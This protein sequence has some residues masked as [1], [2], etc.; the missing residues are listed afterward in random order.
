MTE[1]NI[2]TLKAY[3]GRQQGPLYLNPVKNRTTGK[4]LG[5]KNLSPAE[6]LTA[7][8]EVTADTQR[9]IVDGLILDLSDPVDEIDWAW[10]KENKEIATSEEEANN[11]PQAL[12]Y[13]YEPDREIDATLEKSDLEYEAMK[14]IKESTAAKRREFCMYLGM[15]V[16]GFRDKDV[17]EYLVTTVKAKNGPPRILAI[18][19]DR[20][21]KEKLF[22][23]RLLKSRTVT[24]DK[25]GIYKYG[26]ILIGLNQDAAI[27]WLNDTKNRDIVGK[28]YS[29]LNGSAAR[30]LGSVIDE[31]ESHEASESGE[32]GQPEGGENKAGSSGSAG[33]AS[34]GSK[35]ASQKTVETVEE[36]VI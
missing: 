12:F 27:M 17:E 5:V 15:D 23:F 26:D 6:K 2:I 21:F 35:T 28:L 22:L 34:T 25:N 20:N 9:K 3:Y 7:I 19:N 16:D 33:K 31:F 1:S 10:I 11:N 24:K 8:K 30:Q 14:L 18:R 32:T 4:L 13:V 29:K 36:E